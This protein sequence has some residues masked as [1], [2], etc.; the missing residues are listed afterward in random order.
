MTVTISR[1]TMMRERPFGILEAAGVGYNA[2]SILAS[3]ADNGIRRIGKRAPI[4]IAIACR[5]IKST[6]RSWSAEPTR[7]PLRRR[8]GTL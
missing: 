7:G 4:L 5:A 3:N 2:I 6:P 1:L 8:Q